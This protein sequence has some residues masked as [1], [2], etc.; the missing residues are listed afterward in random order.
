MP[1]HLNPD[2]VPLTP[3]HRPGK[4]GQYM[5]TSLLSGRTSI[6]VSP[7][8]HP[9]QEPTTILSGSCPAARQDGIAPASDVAQDRERGDK[10]SLKEV[11]GGWLT[12][13]GFVGKVLLTCPD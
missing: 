3:F 13:R 11:R 2:K 4:Y 7:W 12:L 6:N 10:K 5:Q 9:S 1:G 8:T